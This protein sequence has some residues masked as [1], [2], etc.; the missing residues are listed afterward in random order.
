A[1]G[2][3]PGCPDCGRSAWPTTPCPTPVG[4]GPGA[5]PLRRRT[6]PARSGSRGRPRARGGSPPASGG[7][8][9]TTSTAPHPAG[10]PRRPGGPPAIPRPAGPAAP[11]AGRDRE[12]P[13]PPS[14]T[15]R[16]AATRGA[17]QWRQCSGR[18]SAAALDGSASSCEGGHGMRKYI[19]MGVQGSGKGTQASFF[20]ESYDLDAVIL[21]E[22]PD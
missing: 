10:R 20:L 11:A 8:A 5:L 7:S 1:P 2:P 14:W 16:G 18:P 4:A 12:G 13:G 9:A 19:I 6:A 21:L 17:S 15:W 3:G 22:V